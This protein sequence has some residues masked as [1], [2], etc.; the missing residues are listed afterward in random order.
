MIQPLDE[1]LVERIDR[2]IAALFA[3]EDGA[4]TGISR[5]LKAPGFRP[6]KC[7]LTKASS[8]I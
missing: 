4:L 7:P 1:Q 6:F 8:C 2:Y 3:P 5:K